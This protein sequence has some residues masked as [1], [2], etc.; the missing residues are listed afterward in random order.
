M[1]YYK[2]NPRFLSYRVKWDDDDEGA[3]ALARLKLPF[4]W[5]LDDLRAWARECFDT[6]CQHEHDCCGGIYQTLYTYD[7]KRVKSRTYLVRI[8]YIRNV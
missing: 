5:T 7:A 8:R 4:G 6:Y 1:S 2:H 3:K